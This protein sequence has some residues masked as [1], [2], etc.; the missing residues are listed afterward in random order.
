LGPGRAL[1]LRTLADAWIRTLSFV[2][3]FAGV[4]A[5]VTAGYRTSYPTLADRLR[6]AQTFGE[7]KAA[8]LFYGTPHHLE[9]VGGF[10]SWR[11]GVLTLFAAFFGLVAAVRAFRGEE[12]TG[13]QELVAAGVITRSTSFLARIAAIGVTVVLLWL[14]MFLGLVAA[15]LALLGSAY[16]AAATVSAAAVYVAVGALA[17]QLMPSRRGALE[18]AGGVLGLDFLLR[19]VSD[20][21]DHQGLHWA[22]PLGWVEE[23]RPFADQRPAVLLLPAAATLLL[24]LASFALERRRDLGVA[25]FAPHD[26]A[27]RQRLRLLGSPTALAFRA[28]RISLTVWVLA[29]ATFAF[30]IGTISKSVASGLSPSIRAQLAKIGVEVVTPSGYIGLTF[31]FFVLAISLFCC[32]QLGAAREEEAEG[33]LETVFSRS[34]SRS[35]WLAGRLGL[36]VG[37]AALIAVASGLGS[38]LGATTVGVNASFPRLLEA[39]F[40]CLPASLL[41]LGLGALFLAFVPRLGVGA[42]YALVSL[43]FV[44]ELFGALLG[45]PGWLLGVSPFH[46]IGLVPAASFRAGPAAIMLAIGTAAAAIAVARFRRRDLVG[47]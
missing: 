34:Q 4:A 20:A 12:E 44:W 30:V 35:R 42:A 47:A 38:A 23:V 19:V 7:N 33:R 3:L 2:L 14:A 10:V 13:R 24:L 17:S 43:A 21:T 27:R 28:E 15:G 37:G 39:G 40:N 46:Q 29:T 32:S 26:T 45:T 31:L 6:L 1:A 8:R 11:A 25:V 41:F 16:L 18:L 9:T 5:A 22:I 36:A